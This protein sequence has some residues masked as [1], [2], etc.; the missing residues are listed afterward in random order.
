MRLLKVKAL[1][2]IA[3]GLGWYAV[4]GPRLLARRAIIAAID[5]VIGKPRPKVKPD[6]DRG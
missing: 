5:A 2:V 3:V 4:G 6:Q 1:A